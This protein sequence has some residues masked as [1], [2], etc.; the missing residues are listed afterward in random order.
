[1]TDKECVSGGDGRLQFGIAAQ[2]GWWVHRIGLG[3]VQGEGRG[4][5]A[6]GGTAAT[7]MALTCWGTQ[8]AWGAGHGCHL[9]AGD[10]GKGVARI[11]GGS[12]QHQ[13]AQGWCMLGRGC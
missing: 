1:M 4:A 2:Q 8:P 12:G 5:G 7:I 13:R 6:Q 3:G 9:V 10:R 11:E